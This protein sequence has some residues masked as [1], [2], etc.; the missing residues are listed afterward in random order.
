M[1]QAIAHNS[2]NFL[3]YVFNYLINLDLEHNDIKIVTLQFQK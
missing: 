2:L 3:V 1:Q